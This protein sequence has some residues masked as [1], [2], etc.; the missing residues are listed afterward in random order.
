MNRYHLT[1]RQLRKTRHLTAVLSIPIV[2]R[3]EGLS[4]VYRQVGVI[5]LDSDTEAGAA[6]LEQNQQALAEYFTR[7]GK[8]L[9]ELRA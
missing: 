4:P 9:A 3:T 8:I 7:F 5:N 6:L 1:K 2:K